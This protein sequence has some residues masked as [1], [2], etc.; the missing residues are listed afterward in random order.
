[1]SPSSVDAFLVEGLNTFLVLVFL[2]KPSQTHINTLQRVADCLPSL[3]NNLS[4]LLIAHVW[5]FSFDVRRWFSLVHSV[6]TYLLHG[7]AFG[8]VA[9]KQQFLPLLLERLLLTNNFF[10]AILILRE[11][12]TDFLVLF[13]EWSLWL[14]CSAPWRL[15]WHFQL[16]DL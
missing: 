13:F 8:N 9:F 2:L 3:A 7:T 15:L 4:S 10:A 6:R 11:S 16:F 5:I 1:M 12:K 14:C